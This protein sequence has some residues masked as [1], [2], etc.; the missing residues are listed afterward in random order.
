MYK[1]T[2]LEPAKEGSP[3]EFA[4]IMNISI[5]D[6]LQDLEYF[7]IFVVDAKRG[8]ISFNMKSKLF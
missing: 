1:A 3:G 6:L 4:Y 2:G 5:V 8:T 7:V